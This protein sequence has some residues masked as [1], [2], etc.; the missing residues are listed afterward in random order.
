M[1]PSQ[2]LSVRNLVVDIQT[3]KGTLSPVRSVDFSIG[4]GESVCLVGE[5][6]CGKSVTALSLLKLLPAPPFHI[7]AGQ[8]LF[9]RTDLAGLSP[10]Q[11]CGIRGKKIAMIFQEPMTAL[12]PVFTIGEQIEE[13]IRTHFRMDPDQRRRKA[14]DLLTQAGIPEPGQRHAA[15]PH[16]LSGGLRQRAMIAMA[17]ACDP[18]LLI[19][20]EPTTALDV[21]VQAQILELL[22]RLRVEHGLSLLL[23]THNLGVVAHVAS[24]VLIMYAGKIVEES[25]V[26]ALFEDPLHPYTQALL[27]AVPYGL[28]SG[29]RRL[30]SV[31]GSV[32]ALESIP[33]GCAFH[34]RCPK[35]WD[36]CTKTD[37]AYQTRPDGRRVACHL[38]G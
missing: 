10:A 4:R 2:L 37:P 24:R 22:D 17:L 9:D 16:Q 31:P 20:D 6:G 29:A 13:A 27:A 21:T 25:G 28:E 33:P 30:K 36:L 7:R 8:I 18:E 32:P 3:E 23:I 11:M 26:E 35:A 14:I 1:N 38:F 12:N 15:F 5:S 19:A 34:D